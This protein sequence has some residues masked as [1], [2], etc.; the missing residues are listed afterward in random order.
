ME[1]V[2]G[3]IALRNHPCQKR[4]GAR[5]VEQHARPGRLARLLREGPR[6]RTRVFRRA[7]RAADNVAPGDWQ[8]AG[9]RSTAMHGDKEQDHRP[10][11]RKEFRAATT[12][13]LVATDLASRGLPV[14]EI[15]R[16]IDDDVSAEPE[17]YVHRVGRTERA[18][19]SGMSV[20]FCAPHEHAELRAIE[21]SAR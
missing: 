20:T 9:V 21:T 6:E 13:V 18:G 8:R 16:V 4:H 12:S 2:E 17:T 3:K 19:A 7:E 15:A 1:G 11:V 14:D 10:R 5:F